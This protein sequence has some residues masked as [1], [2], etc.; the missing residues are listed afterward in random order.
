MVGVVGRVGEYVHPRALRVVGVCGVRVGVGATP[1][2][3]SRAPA[4]AVTH[5][6]AGGHAQ[7]VNKY[8]ISTVHTDLMFFFMQFFVNT[9]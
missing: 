5:K 6:H 2:R 8:N 7:P 4:A 3:A 1:A 9:P